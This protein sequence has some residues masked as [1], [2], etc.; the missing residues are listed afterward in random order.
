MDNKVVHT[1]ARAALA[2]GWRCVRFNFRGVG[3]SE[4]VWDQGVG[5]IEDALA[6]L[7]IQCADGEPL[8]V[9]GF[10]FGA[11]VASHVAVHAHHSG[12]AVLGTQL[13]APATE[14]FS[15]APPLETIPT[16]VIHGDA[17]EVVPLSSTLAWARATVQPVCVFPG[18][19]HFFHGQLPRLRTVLEQSLRSLST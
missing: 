12:A 3:A 15:V 2:T 9:A 11:Y 5:E 7:R 4:G 14:N 19:G 13:I 10:S 8:V 6:V 18:V 1:I 17:D 16:L